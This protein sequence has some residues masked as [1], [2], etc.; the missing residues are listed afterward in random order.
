MF[1]ILGVLILI[2]FIGGVGTV[3][4]RMNRPLSRTGSRTGG[5]ALGGGKTG[6]RASAGGTKSGSRASGGGKSSTRAG[7]AA[8]G[9]KPS[10]VLKAWNASGAPK[11]SE[12][13]LGGA[14]AV[15]TGKAAGAVSR[16]GWLVSKKTGRA[17]RWFAGRAM[18]PF[19]RW[20]ASWQRRLE[21]A[22]STA[23]QS[24]ATDT[25][26]TTPARSASA[27]TGGDVPR[28]RVR[29]NVEMAGA[30]GNVGVPSTLAAHID[31]LNGM[32]FEND[33]EYLN[34]LA[35]EVAGA[36]A[37]AEAIEHLHDVCLNG[38][39]LDPQ[40]IRGLAT[41]AEA[42]TEFADQA[43]S[44]HSEFNEVYNAVIGFVQDGGKLPH[45]GRWLTGDA[46]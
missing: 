37:Y 40:A 46:A 36:I 39:G 4:H 43:K 5:K 26:T 22:T 1:L 34:W 33:A 3:A 11:T 41:L 32:E 35:G 6:S 2:V 17:G 10:W 23:E 38:Q 12:S 27:T 30:N 16:G 9:R 25:T 24:P 45:D 28:P 29:R 42:K 21:S 19:D 31:A 18:T 14:A 8:A 15:V 44:A 20:L 13:T 7:R